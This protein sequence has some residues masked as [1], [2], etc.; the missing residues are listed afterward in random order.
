MRVV[1]RTDAS[2]RI[3]SGHVARCVTLAKELRDR[4]AEVT[5]VVGDHQQGWYDQIERHGM[6][7]ERLPRTAHER[8]AIADGDYGGWLG[9]TQNDDAEQTLAVIDDD[10]DLLIVDHYGLGSV[11][12]SRLRGAVGRLMAID[13][14]TGR[15]HDVDVLLDQNLRTDGG[16]ARRATAPAEA[17]V[18]VG[19]AYALVDPMFRRA[20]ADRPARR[21]PG[22]VL[23]TLGASPAPALLQEVVD[24]LA[25]APQTFCDVH[26]VD[27][28][29]QLADRSPRAGVGSVVV[30]EK[31]PNLVD[32]LLEADVVVGSGGGTTWERATLGLASVTMALAENQ[33]EV[34]QELAS[35]DAVVHLGDGTAENALLCE[36]AVRDL[37]GDDRRRARLGDVGAWLVDGAGT[38][39]VAEFL[40]PSSPELSV[41]PVGRD[42]AG[43]LWHIANDAEVRQQA[44][45]SAPIPWD[46]HLDWFEKRLA[47]ENCDIYLLES[48]GV[49]VG[50][51]R[52]DIEKATA[53]VDYALLAGVRGRGLGR[54]LI[55]R[56]TDLLRARRGG[57]VR[58]V[59][60]WVRPENA[61]SLRVF[62]RAS[63]DAL[64]VRSV[65]GLMGFVRTL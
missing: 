16:V 46:S 18:L 32:L 34:L 36:R 8:E 41:R 23:V 47:D 29:G 49:P 56:G 24:R 60:A 31:Q 1:F 58:T 63:F 57:Q 35:V 53:T 59:Q 50:Q 30:H 65:D 27:V 12:E 3:G 5:F 61:A 10:V 54:E 38:F 21:I 7:S 15:V 22:R 33:R 9:A 48:D 52:F 37:L 43:I 42:D 45:D 40:L 17:T 64:P 4:G 55:E 25:S 13:D 26:V 2:P 39:R 62:Q 19:P 20:R 14:L 11:W 6:A 28:S 51:I 44:V